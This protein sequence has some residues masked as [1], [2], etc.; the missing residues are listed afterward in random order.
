MIKSRYHSFNY[1]VL[2]GKVTKCRT[3]GSIENSQNCKCKIH[4]THFA[5]FPLLVMIRVLT[6]QKV[7]PCIFYTTLHIWHISHTNTQ[8]KLSND[9]WGNS[10]PE[11]FITDQI[12]STLNAKYLL[13][14]KYRILLG[15]PVWFSRRL[16]GIPWGTPK[17][18][19]GTQGILSTPGLPRITPILRFPGGSPWILYTCTGTRNTWENVTNFWLSSLN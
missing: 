4:K 1:T 19:L 9:T 10:H 8:I 11:H 17:F 6:T 7:R 18:P 14:M 16:P 2:E 13:W 3:E 5:L 15:T 12:D